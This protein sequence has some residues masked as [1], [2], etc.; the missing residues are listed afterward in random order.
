MPGTP[1]NSP[2]PTAKPAAKPETD[3][4]AFEDAY[5]Y[6]YTGEFKIHKGILL[7]EIAFEIE[8]KKVANTPENLEWKYKLAER[9]GFTREE[10]RDLKNLDCK[11]LPR[12]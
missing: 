10:L 8:T 12:A 6:G 9:H 2:K 5:I 4:I 11:I 3:P 1:G 7:P